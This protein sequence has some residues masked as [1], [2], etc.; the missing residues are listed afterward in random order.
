MGEPAGGGE[1]VHVCTC[2]RAPAG[3]HVQTCRL[4][5]DLTSDNA[6]GQTFFFEKIG[7]FPKLLG[8]PP[9]GSGGSGRSPGALG[10]SEK[11][12]L[13]GKLVDSMTSKLP[14]T[15]KLSFSPVLGRPGP[16]HGQEIPGKSNNFQEN[17]RI[18]KEILVF[19]P[20]M[21]VF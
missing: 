12:V 7:F 19:W 8:R 17:H 15:T 3:L 11:L 13:L 4:T 2:S 18:S 1:H 5:P 21:A 10:G 14:P 20:K 9:G 6:A 16:G